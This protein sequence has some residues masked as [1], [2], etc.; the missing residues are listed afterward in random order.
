[1]WVWNNSHLPC[2]PVR[3]YRRGFGLDIKF[4]DHLQV[5]LKTTMTLS[6]FPQFTVHCYT[7]SIIASTIHFLATDFNTGTLTVSL[8]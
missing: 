8:N 6:L 5:V 3:D 1:M 7:Q 4:I 2:P